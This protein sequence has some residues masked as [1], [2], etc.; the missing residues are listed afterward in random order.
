MPADTFHILHHITVPDWLR[1]QAQAHRFRLALSAPSHRG[2]RDRLGYAQLV[3][4]MHAMARGLHARGL[5]QGD[6]LALLLPNTAAREGIL[7][8]LGCWQLGAAVS[9]LNRRFTDEELEHALALLEPAM[10]VVCDTN[11]ARRIE[12]LGIA[13]ERILRLDG[14]PGAPS[15]WPEPEDAPAGALPPD[16]P[17]SPH[18][19]SCLLFTSGTTA[20]A[21]AVMH[22][23][24]TQLHTGL[25]MGGALGLTCEDTYQGP[26]PLHTSSVLNLGCMSAWV[27][28]AGVV[29]EE[30]TLDNGG[31]LRLIA[32][33]ASTV[34]H[35]VPAP[36]HFLIDEFERG[37]YDVG[38]VRRVA[39]GGAAMP[40]EI[41]ERYARLWPHADQV[42]VWGMTET[43]PAG[44]ALPPWML[45]RQA[46]AIGR[47]QPGCAIRILAD[48][49]GPGL[50][51]APPGE[52]GEIAFAG[53]SASPGYFRNEAATAET[54]VDGWVLTGD[55][56]WIDGEGVVH[57]VDRKKDIIN[58]GGLKIS[59]AAIEEV[60]YR[61]PGIAEASVIAVPHPKLGEDVAACVVPRPGITLDT[62][63]LRA[64]CAQS[65]ADNQVPRHWFVLQKLPRNGLGKVLKRELRAQVLAPG[66]RPDT[67]RIR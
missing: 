7:T 55:L 41:I 12:A 54:F 6:R 40:V 42:Q 17:A 8:A 14:P 21:K 64:A 47:P 32:S 30:D 27:H 46:G 66:P 49:E 35:G 44:T 16:R 53:P 50:R 65:L 18:D 3:V 60:L 56:G 15:T 2:H 58:R 36:L 39:Y 61:C 51:D 63:A 28:G 34:Y 26:W 67:T 13:P 33:E 9:P 57:F 20:R 38:C 5:R 19:L 62:E 43:G 22:T 1:Q 25:A 31:R 48:G 11:D 23:H 4:R 59:S 29:L 45:P 52:V 24:R 37:G 10:A